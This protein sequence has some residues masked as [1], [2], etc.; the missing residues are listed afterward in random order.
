MSDATTRPADTL[1]IPA[2]PAESSQLDWFIGEW[3]VFSRMRTSTEPEQWAEDTVT[4]TVTPILHH[5]ALLETFVGALGGQALEGISIRTYNTAINRWEQRWLDTTRSAF[6]EYTGD[7]KEGQFIGYANT[8]FKDDS[9]IELADK[10][11]RELFFDIAPDRFSWRLEG[12]RDGG[13]TWNVVWTLEYT[14]RKAP[15]TRI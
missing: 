11:T 15:Q 14:R 7:F 3:D 8:S 12:S 10:A 9:R 6:A 13:Q 4:S 5:F 2:P 1:P